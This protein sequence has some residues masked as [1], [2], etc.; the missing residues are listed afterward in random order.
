MTRWRQRVTIERLRT[1][2]L[3]GG[4]VLVVAIV[5]FLALGHWT[6]RFLTKDLPHRLGADIEQSAD[7]VTYTQTNRKGKTVFKIHAA[8][9]V[10]FKGGGKMELSDCRAETGLVKTRYFKEQAGGEDRG[11]YGGQWCRTGWSGGWRGFCFQWSYK[12]H[13]R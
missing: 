10:K 9:A 8:R 4:G 3:I 2:V 12:S 5:A 1:L 6:R 13:Y 11:F 7:G